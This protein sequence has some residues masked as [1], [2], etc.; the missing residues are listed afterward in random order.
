VARI[1][2]VPFVGAHVDDATELITTMY[3][4][5]GG[6]HDAYRRVLTDGDAAKRLIADALSDG[7]IAAVIGGRLVGFVLPSPTPLGTR[8]RLECHG[9]QIDDRRAIYRALYQAFAEGCS[10]S[11]GRHLIAVAVADGTAVETFFELG[12]GVDQIRGIL[13]LRGDVELD[14]GDGAVAVATSDDVDVLAALVAELQSFHV[15]PPM[16]GDAWM[17]EPTMR[18][19]V[20]ADLARTDGTFLKAVEGDRIVGLAAVGAEGTFPGVAR[21][22]MAVITEVAR[23][24]GIGRSLAGRAMDWARRSGYEWCEVGWTSSNPISDGFWRGLGFVPIRY[25]LARRIR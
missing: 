17:D 20:V 23:G 14:A 3:S 22:G 6:L 12:F 1:D 10:E 11:V 2:V 15:G 19:L 13:P 9:A 24:H 21:I 8:I 4:G 5:L 7:A 18:R 16:F 25:T